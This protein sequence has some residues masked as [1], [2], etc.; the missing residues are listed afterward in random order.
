MLTQL[1]SLLVFDLDCTTIHSS[2]SWLMMFPAVKLAVLSGCLLA[3]ALTATAQSNYQVVS[4]S[5][6]GSITG[7]VKWS[8]VLPR[9]PTF[10]INKDTEI[11]DPESHKTRDLER[12]I[13]GPTGG[14]ANTVVFLKNISSGKAVNLPESR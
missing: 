6:P 8:G 2:G 11:C 12:L 7:T 13:V 1:L 3:V 9:I 10:T 14:V 4:L 5:N